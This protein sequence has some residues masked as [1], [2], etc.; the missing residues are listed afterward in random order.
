MLSVV[1]KKDQKHSYGGRGGRHERNSVTSMRT[2]DFT[3]RKPL[4]KTEK[5]RSTENIKKLQDIH[6]HIINFRQMAKT[7]DDKSFG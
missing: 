2:I 7:S 4:C 6:N 3:V 5:V 1:Q